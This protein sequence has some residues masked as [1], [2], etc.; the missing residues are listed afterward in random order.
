M[1]KTQAIVTLGLLVALNILLSRFLSVQPTPFLR[2]NFGFLAVAAAG[3]LFGP[4]AGGA[5]A[6]VAD[7]LGCF[8]FPSGGAYFPGIT[9]SALLAG[10]LYGAFLHRRRPSLVR[11]LLAA[12][13]VCLLVDAGLTT[14]WLTM[15]LPGKTFAV[16]FWPRLVKSLV[17]IPI[18]SVMLFAFWQ[19]LQ[20]VRPAVS[21]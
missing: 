20:R 1:K 6:A 15:I 2:I 17:A 21:R 4:W 12:A 3:L 11:C 18:Q 8:I 13:S 9:I 5:A 7:V 14:F 19:V 10:I 16:L